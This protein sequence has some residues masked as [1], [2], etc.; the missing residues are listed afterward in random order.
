MATMGRF[1]YATSQKPTAVVGSSVAAITGPSD[2][3][4]V[5][6]KTSR[7][8]LYNV[9]DEGIQP[10]AEY[11]LN[12]RIATLKTVRLNV[13]TWNGSD[14]PAAE[15]GFCSDNFARVCRVKMSTI[16]WPQPNTSSFLS[17]IGIRKRKRCPRLQRVT[18]ECVRWR[19]ESH[20]KQ[21]SRLLLTLCRIEL[22]RLRSALS[23]CST[24]TASVLP[25]TCARAS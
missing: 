2:L 5:L 14:S 24:P 21:R 22:A 7:I 11:A 25:S 12:G 8:D 13:C 20:Q 15:E 1:Y 10:I 9:T 6:A 16:S 18:Y 17:C 23:L 4:L 3:N 19:P